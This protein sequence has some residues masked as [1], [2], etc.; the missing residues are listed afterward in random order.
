MACCISSS[1]NKHTDKPRLEESSR[2]DKITV[3]EG[4]TL[5][6]ISSA[7][8]N[9][10]PS[11]TW[12][13]PLANPPH[14]IN[15]SI[16]TIK[17]VASEHEGTYTCSA[18]NMAGDVTVTFNVEVQGEFHILPCS[19]CTTV[20]LLSVLLSHSSKRSTLERRKLIETNLVLG[21]V[22]ICS[23]SSFFL[24]V[25]LTQLSAANYMPY[26]IIAVLLSFVLVLA[27]VFVVY[28]HYYKRNRM[29]QYN[30][31]DVFRLQKQLIPTYSL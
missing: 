18:R 2:S 28:V 9:P 23:V 27:C 17:S 31:K 24:P 21:L 3:T 5:H 15:G 10:T 8:G 16:L 4:D 19:F 6:L 22:L 1:L 26:I 11:Y 29:G 14:L 13:L 12:K 25:P 7:V 30:M 20:V